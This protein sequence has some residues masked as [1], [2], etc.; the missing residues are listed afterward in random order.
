M[1]RREALTGLGAL[2]VGMLGFR[3][4]AR[5]QTPRIKLVVVGDGAVGKTC[6]L[7]SYTTN[8][9][10]G[11]YIPTVFDEYSA[12]VSI[13][14]HPQLVQLVDTSEKQEASR[15]GA[16]AGARVILITYSIISPASW[17]NARTRWVDEV[18]KS[19]PGVPFLFVGNKSD[20]RDDAATLQTL[21]AKNLAPVTKIEGVK[22]ANLLG[23]AAHRECSA[24]TQAG[25][26]DVFDTAIRVTFM[27][28]SKR[29]I[30]R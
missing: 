18:K 20:L 26:K 9:F 30:F 10:P 23:A 21:K 14:G 2:G 29:G 19:A 17:S 13:D 6:L 3:S 11:E 24:L 5:A 16:Y 1:K 12:S 25:L 4:V 22:H 7:I 15:K 27:P 28:P 8:A